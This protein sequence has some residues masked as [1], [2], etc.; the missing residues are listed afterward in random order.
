MSDLDIVMPHALS[1]RPGHGMR[2]AVDWSR[3]S[4][5]AVWELLESLRAEGQ[6]I[7]LTTHMMD[8]ADQLCD[9]IAIIDYGRLLALD[10]PGALKHHHGGAPELRLAADEKLDVLVAEIIPATFFGAVCYPWAKAGRRTLAEDPRPRQPTRPHQQSAPRRATASVAHMA[11]HASCR[12]MAAFTIV[13]TT[14]G[15]RGLSRR[16]TS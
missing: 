16:A 2:S 13:L 14:A 3:C 12:V 1:E 6:T 5:V 11:L 8:E 15:I 10:R 9:Q 7:L 4:D